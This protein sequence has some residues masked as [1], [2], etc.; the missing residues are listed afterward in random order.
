MPTS[1]QQAS[2]FTL[3]GSAADSVQGLRVHAEPGRRE[4]HSGLSI[5]Q[6]RQGLD[7]VVFVTALEGKLLL[8]QYVIALKKSGTRVSLPSGVFFAVTKSILT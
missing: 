5:S 1:R 2:E 6:P 8:R 4:V 3:Q 7:H